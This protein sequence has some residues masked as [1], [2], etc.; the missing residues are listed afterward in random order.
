MQVLLGLAAADSGEALIQGRRYG[1]ISR[2]LTVVGAL[3]DAGAFHP[4]RSARSHLQWLAQT[5]GIPTG[6]ATRR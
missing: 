4:S 1:T 5:N 6:R 3:L 2:P